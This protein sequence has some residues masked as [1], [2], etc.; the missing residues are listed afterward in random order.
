MDL[1]SPTA[2]LRDRFK[3]IAEK[4]NK[5][6]KQKQLRQLEVQTT[7]PDFWK[8]Y[9]DAQKVMKQIADISKDIQAYE[10]IEKNISEGKVEEVEKKLADLET[11]MFLAG[12][13]DESYAILSI[14]AGQGGVE[15]MDWVEM[16][17]RMY[18]KYFQS[19]RDRKS[20]V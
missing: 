18:Q 9:Q 2:N 1:H 20:V 8:N 16:L 6:E 4:F 12:P 15:A 7:H 14:H 10:E 19:K 11:K 3:V 17:S 13:Y 5:E